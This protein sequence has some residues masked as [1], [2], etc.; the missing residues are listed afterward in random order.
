MKV[1]PYLTRIKFR[2]Y[3]ESIIKAQLY[4]FVLFPVWYWGSCRVIKFIFIT[5]VVILWNAHSEKELYFGFSD[6]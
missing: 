6:G 4:L 3:F 5:F 1:L 2:A